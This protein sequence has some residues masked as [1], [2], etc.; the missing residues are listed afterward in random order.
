[1]RKIGSALDVPL[2][3]NQLHGGRTPI[4]PQA[5]LK[6]MGYSVAIYATAGLFAASQALANVYAALAQGKP[7]KE[8]LYAFDDFVRMIG[9]QEVWDF[10][11]KYA[12]LLLEATPA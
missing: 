5:Q 7:V 10:E 1:M 11:E 9:F 12:D 2:L 3:S 6:A 4:L 8:P